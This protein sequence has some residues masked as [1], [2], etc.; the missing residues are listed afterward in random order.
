MVCDLWDRSIILQTHKLTSV[1]LKFHQR[2]KLKVK[3][4]VL[5]MH[6]SNQHQICCNV[7]SSAREMVLFK[8][9]E[10]YCP[11]YAYKQS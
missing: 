8:P 11:R 2:S 10:N 3:K 7:W 6:I 5:I 9:H 4:C 1:L